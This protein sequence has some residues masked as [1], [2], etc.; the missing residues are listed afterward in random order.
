MD[1]LIGVLILV[2]CAIAAIVA[3]GNMNRH[4]MWWWICLYWVI[5]TLKNLVDFAKFIGR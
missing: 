5:L 3:V 2:L 4:D 1:I